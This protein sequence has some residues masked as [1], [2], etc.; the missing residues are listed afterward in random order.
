MPRQHHPKPKPPQPYV[1]SVR[2]PGLQ[3]DVT[4]DKPGTSLQRVSEAVARTLESVAAT[5]ESPPRAVRV[6]PSVP[7]ADHYATLG[8]RPDA[9]TEEIQDAHFAKLVK[10]LTNASLDKAI[11]AALGERERRGTLSS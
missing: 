3:I 7:F 4:I 5:L 10:S 8:V 1:L 11:D 2:G 9:T 6:D